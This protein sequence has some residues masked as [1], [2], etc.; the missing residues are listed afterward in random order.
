MT[1][2]ILRSIEQ[3]CVDHGVA[4]TMFGRAAVKDPRLVGDLRL[5]RQPKPETVNRIA[6][7]IR[8]GHPLPNKPRIAVPDQPREDRPNRTRGGDRYV[9][10]VSDPHPILGD[11]AKFLAATGMGESTF[12]LMAMGDP[13]FVEDLRCGRD[14]LRRTERRVREFMQTEEGC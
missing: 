12:G 3:Y 2:P 4:P 6:S 1:A 8:D 10:R 14:I 11:I 5:G 7:Y 9:Y 13:N